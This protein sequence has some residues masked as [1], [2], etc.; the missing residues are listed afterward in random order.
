MGDEEGMIDESMT[1][2]LLS[3]LLDW[4]DARVGFDAAISGIPPRYRGVKPA[5]APHTLWQLLE[6]I[7]IAQHDILDF[8][9]NASYREQKWPDDYW[10]RREKPPSA[11][12]WERSVKQVR[13]DRRALQRLAA[14]RRLA[15][16]DRIPH[17]SGQTY[18]RELVLVA[19]HNAYHVGQIV[20][21]RQL[22]GIWPPKRRAK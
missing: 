1:R 13:R 10:P 3:R 2:E 5:G 9:V 20:L 14:S 19:D 16:T 7:R 12:A 21:L 15:L 11:A 4:E 18:A 17:G 6:H 8:S 22:L